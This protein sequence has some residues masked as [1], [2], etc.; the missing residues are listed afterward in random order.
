M[1]G[2]VKDGEHVYLGV[3]RVY[4]VDDAVVA[5]DEFT[6]GVIANLWDDSSHP[7]KCLQLPGLLQDFLDKVRGVLGSD[8]FVVRLNRLEIIQG[9]GPPFQG[10]R[11][12]LQLPPGALVGR[13]LELLF[14]LLARNSL[15]GLVEARAHLF[16]ED[17]A[18]DHV[19]QSNL[20]LG[21][22]LKGTQNLRL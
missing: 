22:I 14:H 8:L 15:V 21:E 17:K 2:R 5:V 1:L 3:V 4:D 12:T 9:L 6:D 16:Q 18:F 10:C 11:Y 19:L 13:L 7:R 20:L